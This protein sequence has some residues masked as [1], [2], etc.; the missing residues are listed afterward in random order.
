MSKLKSLTA[1]AL[2]AT[3]VTLAGCAQQEEEV[4]EI[5]NPAATFCIESGGT[6]STQEIKG[7]A[8][9]FCTL[10]S[11]ETVDAWEYFRENAPT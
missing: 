1:V 11:G 10:P 4:V 3:S 9:G 2:A 5:A 7:G 8:V 6:Y